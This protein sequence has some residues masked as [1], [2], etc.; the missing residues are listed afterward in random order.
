MDQFKRLYKPVLKPVKPGEKRVA[1]D[2]TNKFDFAK[3][4]AKII[5]NSDPNRE[6][7][8]PAV[9]S[10]P[11]TD[12]TTSEEKLYDNQQSSTAAES[13]FVFK[14]ASD[15]PKLNLNRDGLLHIK[16]P[17]S[18]KDQSC[19]KI[20]TSSDDLELIG[21]DDPMISTNDEHSREN[22]KDNPQKPSP[23]KK[24]EPLTSKAHDES[25]QLLDQGELR[26]MQ[27]LIVSHLWVNF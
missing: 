16:V 1:T 17:S 25:V 22:E 10:E 6:K 14:P 9:E 26:S 15:V 3:R 2:Q 19:D 5:A 13:P 23:I 21:S 27:C 20:D 8:T 12:I 24:I 7:S 18:V 11:K 4:F